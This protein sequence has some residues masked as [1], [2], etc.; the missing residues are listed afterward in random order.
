[1]TSDAKPAGRPR[2]LAENANR[3]WS[4]FN[5]QFSPDGH[6]VAYQ[7]D[8]SGQ[9]EITVVPFA[10]G[11]R[12]LQVSKGGGIWPRWASTGLTLYYLRLADEMLV[13]LSLKENAGALEPG[14]TKELF[15]PRI[16][17]GLLTFQ[18][19]VDRLGRFLIN[20]PLTD[21]VNA[22]LTLIEHWKPPVA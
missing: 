20:S 14:D 3:T 16:Y 11:V 10:G 2:E 8:E 22:P 13:A 19:D 9:R 17:D 15:K 1:M 7:T 6:F 18:Y 4:E 5:G 21:G 12:P